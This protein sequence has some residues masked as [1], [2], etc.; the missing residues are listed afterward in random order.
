LGPL[1]AYL[2]LVPFGIICLR[3]SRNY[4]R[5]AGIKLTQKEASDYM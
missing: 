1:F 5:S 2:A 4:A 3:L